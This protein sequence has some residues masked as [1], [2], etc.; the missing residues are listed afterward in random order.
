MPCPFGVIVDHLRPRPT[1]PL[2]RRSSVIP[3]GTVV[4]RYHHNRGGRDVANILVVARVKGIGPMLP[5]PVRGCCVCLFVFGLHRLLW[6]HQ[7]YALGLRGQYLDPTSYPTQLPQL[8]SA[9]TI[10]MVVIKSENGGRS[11]YGPSMHWNAI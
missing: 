9:L 7:S 8:F 5:I 2:T 3:S 11:C 1:K 6:Q 4:N 10:L